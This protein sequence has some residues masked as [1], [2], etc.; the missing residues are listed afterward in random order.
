MIKWEEEEEEEDGGGPSIC[1]RL[2]ELP[3][4]VFLFFFFFLSFRLFLSLS[5]PSHLYPCRW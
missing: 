2:I 1:G 4:R 3:R 5:L